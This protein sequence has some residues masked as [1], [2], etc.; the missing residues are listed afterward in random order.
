MSMSIRIIRTILNNNKNAFKQVSFHRRYLSNTINERTLTNRIT[1]RNEDLSQQ[2]P[3]VCLFGWGNGTKKHLLKYSGLFEEKG[4]TT[5][6][7]TTTLLNSLF[8]ISTA[9]KKESENVKTALTDL[10]GDNLDRQIVF[11][12][13]SNG[14]CAISHLT[15]RSL[16]NERKLAGNIKG[17]IFDSCPII[18]NSESTV[19]VEKAFDRVLN[20]PVLKP[21]I[22]FFSKLMGYF[23]VYF[24][25]DVK[26]FMCKMEKSPLHTPQLFM[27]SK[28]DDLA[29]YKDI[30]NFIE[31]RKSIGIDVEHCLWEDSDHVAH[32]KRHEREYREKVLNFYENCLK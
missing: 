29:P 30:L 31:K 1:V 26:T 24:N 18:P 2:S 17:Q 27:F 20:V 10:C 16:L 25:E 23:V 21:A 6:L 15:T 11:Y 4:H 28:N 9:G 19:A 22:R 13:F 32:F 8:R 7:V 3:I 12:S 5:L 14:G